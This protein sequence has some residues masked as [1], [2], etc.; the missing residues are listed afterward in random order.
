VDHN[1][2]LPAFYAAASMQHSEAVHTS[3]DMDCI[4]P[5]AFLPAPNNSEAISPAQQVIHEI[6]SM[7]KISMRTFSC[8]H[9][10]MQLLLQLLL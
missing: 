9:P 2:I 6:S 10:E 3:D 8:F 1:D 7:V 5:T 4:L